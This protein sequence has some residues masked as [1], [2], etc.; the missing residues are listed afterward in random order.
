[1]LC[2][3]EDIDNNLKGLASLLF[4]L[5]A[6]AENGT[7]IDEDCLLL[8]ARIVCDTQKLSEEALNK[9]SSDAKK[10]KEKGGEAA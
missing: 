3:I 6:E 1:M 8:L 5:A 2:K 4:A 9:A 7:F 10:K